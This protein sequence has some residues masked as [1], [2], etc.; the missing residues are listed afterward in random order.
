MLFRDTLNKSQNTLS[1]TPTTAQIEELI[2]VW[3]KMGVRT[4]SRRCYL[5]LT[6][7]SSF[8]LLLFCVL[9]LVFSA[10]LTNMMKSGFSRAD[11]SHRLK[12]CNLEVR[13]LDELCTKRSSMLN[14]DVFLNRQNEGKC[15]KV[16][17]LTFIVFMTMHLLTI[18]NLES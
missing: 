4:D 2:D 1:S 5:G 8:L 14:F 6:N 10:V 9:S 16:R 3:M 12:Y 17:F 13:S 7:W 11:N 18:V 15:N